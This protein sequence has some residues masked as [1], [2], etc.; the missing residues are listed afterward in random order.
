MIEVFVIGVRIDQKT[1]QAQCA[2][3]A[4]Q[5]ACGGLGVLGRDGGEAGEAPRIAGDNLREAVIDALS[6]AVGLVACKHLHARGGQAQ[7]LHLDPVRVHDLEPLAE[8]EQPGAQH[9]AGGDRPENAHVES[10]A[11][12]RRNPFECFVPL[13][14]GKS[15]FDGYKVHEA[16]LLKRG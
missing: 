7:D 15:F 5:L 11:P 1:V 2:H 16:L 12:R 10:M 9:R 13:G 4:F 3:G 6:E 8:V 14:S